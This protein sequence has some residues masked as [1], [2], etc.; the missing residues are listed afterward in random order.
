MIQIIHDACLQGSH[1]T[2]EFPKG[3]LLTEINTS[4]SCDNDYLEKV[5]DQYIESI[6]II[7][8]QSEENI[9]LIVTDLLENMGLE[10]YSDEWEEAYETEIEKYSIESVVEITMSDQK[11]LDHLLPIENKGKIINRPNWDSFACL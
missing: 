11:Y 6:K 5:V 1:Q 9:E 7:N 4:Q 10:M 8:D 3:T 2:F